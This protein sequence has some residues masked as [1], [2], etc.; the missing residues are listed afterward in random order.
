MKI[1]TL[2][3]RKNK[4]TSIAK[5]IV[6]LVFFLFTGYLTH[7]QNPP[8]AVN[9][10][11]STD[12]ATSISVP[13][14]GV[15]GNDDD[16]D[17]GNTIVVTQFVVNG[18][19]YLAGSSAPVS[20][21]GSIIINADGS[22]TF[23]PGS[24]GTT[25]TATYTID[26][27][28]DGTATADLDI[29]VDIVNAMLGISMSNCNQGTIPPTAS[30]PQGQ[31]KIQY[32][33]TLS[34][35]SYVDSIN[36]IQLFDDLNA[37]FNGNCIDLIDGISV[38]TSNRNGN[39]FPQEFNSSDIDNTEFV[40]TDP[41][42][43]AQGIFNAASVASDVLYPRQRINIS[44]CVYID[45]NCAG[46]AGAGSGSGVSF[47]NAIN[48]T[49]SDGNPATS[50]VLQDFHTTEAN[51]AA[52]LYVPVNSPTVNFD[53]T[54]DF[55]NTVVI[56]NDSNLNGQP[57][58]T[59]NN[60]QFYMSMASFSPTI[61][62]NTYVISQVSGPPVT[63]NAS[64]DGLTNT[65]L[66]AP[67]TS[68]AP[69]NTVILEIAYNVGPTT[70]SGSK[71][72]NVINPSMS[73]GA[74]DGDTESPTNDTYVE[75]TDGQGTHV[76]RYYVGSSGTDVPTS[77]DQ[78]SC[79][80][81]SMSFNY[82]V[83]LNVDKTILSETQTGPTSKDV[84]YQIIVGN[85][86]SSEVQIDNL[87]LTDDL[88]AICGAGNVVLTVP[89]SIVASSALADPNL[90]PGFNGTTDIN[91]FDG[92]SGILEPGQQVSLTF[93]VAMTTP[94]VGS[95]S[96]TFSANDPNVI[97]A[98]TASATASINNPPV[99]VDDSDTT[100]INTPV[101]VDVLA[102]DTD[103]DTDP[104]TITEINGNPITDGGAPIV[105]GDGTQVALIGGQL[106]I[107]P[108]SGSITPIS[109]N[110]TV[111]D[112]NGNVDQANVFVT[113]SDPDTDGD[114]T[115]DSID[116]A[117]NDP[118]IDDGTLGDEDA[119]NAVWQAADCDGDGVTNGT[120]N[121]NGTD[122]YN[123]CNPSQP[124]GYTGY[125]ITNTIWQTA[126]C[127]GDGVINITEV[128]P[129]GNGIDDG[130]GTDPYD[131]CDYNV[132]LITQTQTAP[133]IIADCD[134]D[135]VVNGQEVSDGTDPLD[136]CDFNSANQ[137]YS[138]T[139]PAFQTLDCDGDG[140]TNGNEID[141]DGN[142]TDESNGSVPSI[143]S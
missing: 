67:G 32:S 117:P 127:D 39:S 77:N 37:A 71:S 17:G 88:N 106:Q 69:G 128:D 89:P 30:R 23:N 66:L 53:G 130:N 61:P 8:N 65:G 102:N 51:V 86:A 119:S 142:G 52:N 31:Y 36:T 81:E 90:N 70:D 57:G 58:T 38:S 46:G 116:P 115:P 40:A 111:S 33:I 48:A 98:G 100:A 99:A 118:C 45:P 15:L 137:D 112:G 138:I 76:D 1:F 80:S 126:D 121:T 84:V 108:A 131:P 95:N 75:W 136:S 43:G 123:P 19:T 59:A 62:L 94:C 14:P 133:W 143:I 12:T 24:A 139:T 41:T 25:Y 85:D 79:P 13:A 113:I 54:Y 56:T 44:F 109:F 134:G 74:A 16:G 135:G 140:V 92:T 22:Y 122:P 49:S 7:A 63:V 26:D 107:T 55:T 27:G 29:T 34:N 9:D 104:L 50:L 68:L 10:I 83:T 11:N 82:N 91:I 110:Y 78:C 64:Y 6:L 141:P 103:P 47:T 101:T 114:G 125:D 96:A 3:F 20:G 120:E 35:D 21:G 60:V 124:I 28:I 18:N 97:S 132:L 129:D 72:F 73:Q 105:L 87:T 2:F 5:L 93:T 4:N 42:P